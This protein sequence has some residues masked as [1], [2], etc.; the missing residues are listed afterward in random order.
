MDFGNGIERAKLLP[1]I[2]GRPGAWT[3]V[4]WLGKNVD[5]VGDSLG[6]TFEAV[7][8]MKGSL[9]FTA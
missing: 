9:R 1:G 8:E 2:C 3:C 7:V 6:P 5:A 4:G